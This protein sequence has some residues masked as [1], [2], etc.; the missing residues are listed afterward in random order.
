MIDTPALR[1]WAMPIVWLATATI[2][3]CLGRLTSPQ[4]RI[5]AEDRPSAL[6]AQID[7]SSSRST[8]DP[9]PDTSDLDQLRING[10]GIT[11]AEQLAHG[12][13]LEEWLKK[14]FDLDDDIARMTG[15]MRLL[16]VA[17]ASELQTALAVLRETN[18]NWGRSREFPMLMQKW[19]QLEPKAAAEFMGQQTD[20]AALF[21]GTRSVFSTWARQNPQESIAWAQE[22]GIMGQGNDT[23][24]WPM[25][26][27]VNEIA[28]QN[29]DWALQLAEAQPRSQ[30]RGAML[31]A[32]ISGLLEQKSQA[33]VR[34]QILALSD[35]SLRNGMLVNLVS[36]VAREDPA[37]TAAWVQALPAGE[38]RER[39][40]TELINRWSDQDLAGAAAFLNQYPPSPETDGARQRLAE[41]A[42]RNDPQSAIAWAGSIT[43]EEQRFDALSS[44]VRR[45]YRNDADAARAWLQNSAL[46]PEARARL[47]GIR[48]LNAILR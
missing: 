35:E 4:G 46:A 17:D 25:A 48:D 7:A 33:E 16:E 32:M 24:N 30:A 40:M 21:I 19:A 9:F 41:T 5:V 28:E 3:F 10:S 26:V 12:A 14:L 43:Q 18:D 8:A 13:S 47:L 15:F 29:P 39:A 11:S 2:T 1:R 20:R 34:D 23:D 44:V 31:G 36:R 38:G 45:W 6:Q 22:H 37:A 27:I 42:V